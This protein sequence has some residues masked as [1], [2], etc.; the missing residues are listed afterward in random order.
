MAGFAAAR[1]PKVRIAEATI[2][3]AVKCIMMLMAKLG[4][5][6]RFLSMYGRFCSQQRYTE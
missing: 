6:G 1:I 2:V 4:F 5:G 3:G